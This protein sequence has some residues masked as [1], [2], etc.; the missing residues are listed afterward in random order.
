[1][2]TANKKIYYQK[3][4]NFFALLQKIKLWPSRNGL[5]HGIKTLDFK[6]NQAEITTHCGEIFITYNSRNGRAARW[7]RNKWI[8]APC[9]RC[10]VP[11]WKLEKYSTTFFKCNWGSRLKEI[12][13]E[14][15]GNPPLK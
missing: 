5:L 6:G 14:L 13:N 11:A 4:V 12:E 15:H 9:P 3:R 7:L 10:H 2:T 8:V 1:M